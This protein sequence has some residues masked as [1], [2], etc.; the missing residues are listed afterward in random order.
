MSILEE[1]RE[2][3]APQLESYFRVRLAGLTFDQLRSVDRLLRREMD[4][5]RKSIFIE[6]AL[7]QLPPELPNDLEA[8]YER[9][10]AARWLLQSVKMN[11]FKLIGD[12]SIAKVRET[13]NAL[14]LNK[15]PEEK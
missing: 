6:A 5:K 4:K 11:G 13:M 12:P 2:K 9:V 14:C 10:E 1:I 15:L 7:R 3:T 8:G